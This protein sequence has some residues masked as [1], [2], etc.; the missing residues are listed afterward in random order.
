MSA[1]IVRT[2]LHC[3]A[4]SAAARAVLRLQRRLGLP[5]GRE[6]LLGLGEAPE[7]PRRGAREAP[8]EVGCEERPD[9]LPQPL[10]LFLLFLSWCILRVFSGVRSVF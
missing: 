10:F 5:R 8:G 3:M 2:P 6:V 4:R 1:L 9:L 7:G